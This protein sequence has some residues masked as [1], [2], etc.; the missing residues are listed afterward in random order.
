MTSSDLFSNATSH[1][2]YHRLLESF[3]H[4][5][6]KR[7][8]FGDMNFVNMTNV[9]DFLL[10]PSSFTKISI[11]IIILF[12]IQKLIN[13]IYNE[14]HVNAVRDRIKDAAKTHP[15]SFYGLEASK[16]DH[17]TGKINY[18]NSTL[19]SLKSDYVLIQQQ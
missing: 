11:I 14:E 19:L 2:F 16:E 15:S 1:L 9:K 10:P 12:K 6:A 18:K 17:G 5:F 8:H 4:A 13:D 3:K 7:A